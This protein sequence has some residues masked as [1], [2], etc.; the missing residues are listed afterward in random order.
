MK[1]AEVAVKKPPTLRESTRESFLDGKA[2]HVV[3]DEPLTVYRAHGGKA[4]KEGRFTSSDIF[5]S[6]VDVR[7]DLALLPEW[8]NRW[9]NRGQT[10]IN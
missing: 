6:R 4:A 1:N 10:T 2:K 8:D 5:Q 9:D 7:K 3:L